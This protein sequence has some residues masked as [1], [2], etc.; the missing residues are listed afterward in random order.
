[1][2]DQSIRE[3][4]D[5]IRPL[6]IHRAPG[7]IF[8]LGPASLAID[9]RL[10]EPAFLFVSAE[11]STPRLYLIRRRIRDLEK[12]STPPTP[13]SLTLRK[14]LADTQLNAIEKDAPIG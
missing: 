13:F 10:R 4:V 11:P 5:E 14:E 8:Q 6:L 9:F 12:Q 3:I 1:M 2:D 7:K